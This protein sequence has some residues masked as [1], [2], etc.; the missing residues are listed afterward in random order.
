MLST[1]AENAF[2]RGKVAAGR[3]TRQR[4]L[5]GYEKGRLLPLA[6]FSNVFNGKCR[7]FG[8]SSV[9]CPQVIRLDRSAVT[10]AP[11]AFAQTR[12]KLGSRRRLRG[13]PAGAK[14]GGR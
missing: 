3:K 12:T 10:S 13:K 11:Q 2:P 4:A 1:I 14:A 8:P 6:I 9:I 5:Y 7:T